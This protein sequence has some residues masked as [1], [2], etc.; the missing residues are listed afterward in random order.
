[1]G[2]YR[3]DAIGIQDYQTRDKV[4]V[5]LEAMKNDVFEKAYIPLEAVNAMNKGEWDKDFSEYVKWKEE[6]QRY[7]KYQ[8]SAMW[9][10]GNDV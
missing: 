1:M 2:K 3:I 7:L 6:F 10:R 9:Y 5:P 8:L 4:V